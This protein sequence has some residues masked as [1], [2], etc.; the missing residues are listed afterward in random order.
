MKKS[1][2]LISPEDWSESLLT[3]KQHKLKELNR[4]SVNIETA[5]RLWDFLLNLVEYLEV[6]HS[7]EQPLTSSK[8]QNAVGEED[9]REI[10]NTIEKQYEEHDS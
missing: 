4:I 8:I 6:Q 10:R 2:T 1:I 7:I 3:D 5:N 9:D